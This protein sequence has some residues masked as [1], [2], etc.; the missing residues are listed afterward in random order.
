M[1][2]TADNREAN[3]RYKKGNLKCTICPPHD[4]ENRSRRPKSDK[5]KNKRRSK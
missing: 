3:G 5:G 4:K 1:K 2:N